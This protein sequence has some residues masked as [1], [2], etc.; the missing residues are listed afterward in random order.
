MAENPDP[1]CV[2]CG[3]PILPGV[4]RYRRGLESTHGSCERKNDEEG[5][6]PAASAPSEE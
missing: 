5:R 6:L 4:G 2:V 3:K 1:I